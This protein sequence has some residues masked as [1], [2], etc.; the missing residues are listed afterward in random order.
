MQELEWVGFPSPD[1]AVAPNELIADQLSVMKSAVDAVDAYRKLPVVV[2]IYPVRAPGAPRNRVP[3]YS[4]DPLPRL[5]LVSPT[6]IPRLNVGVCRELG[7]SAALEAATRA[8]V[9]VAIGTT[10]E[11]ANLGM[12]I[13]L[14]TAVAPS[15][16]ARVERFF[17]AAYNHLHVLFLRAPTQV[18]TSTVA[19]L[20]QSQKNNHDPASS[21][22]LRRKVSSS[23]RST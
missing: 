16:E 8:K 4:L 15:F 14:P 12:E 21:T 18:G 10:V 20:A 23:S 13:A 6:T 11:I 1:V 9:Q 5:G 17:Q 22:S 2:P 19:H 3:Q 7:I